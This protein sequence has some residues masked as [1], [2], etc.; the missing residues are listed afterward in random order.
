M[1]ELIVYV[2]GAAVMI[3]GMIGAAALVATWTIDRVVE[4]TQ[5]TT[6]IGQWYVDKLRKKR[7][8]ARP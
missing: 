7:K 6:I 8:G 4:A 5:S 2:F 3:L 1:M